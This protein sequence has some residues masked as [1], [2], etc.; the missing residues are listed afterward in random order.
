MSI[1]TTYNSFFHSPGLFKTLSPFQLGLLLSLAWIS[2]TAAA[3]FLCLCICLCRC[4]CRCRYLCKYMCLCRYSGSPGRCHHYS[5]KCCCLR[6]GSIVQ[7]LP[8]ICVL[9]G[10]RVD[11]DV[12]VGLC[13]G[14]GIY[15]S[16]GVYIDTCVFVFVFVCVC[17]DT[18]LMSIQLTCVLLHL[19]TERALYVWRTDGRCG[20]R[21]STI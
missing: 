18:S 20:L 17:I 14:V 5:S 8:S 16:T 1:Q 21:S 7:Q 4:R 6:P 13:V 2:Y 3:T 11:V 10:V 19:L 9:V 15:V 12:C